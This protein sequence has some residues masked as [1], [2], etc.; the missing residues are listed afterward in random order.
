MRT[1]RD[2]IRVPDAKAD[3]YL[4]G[5]GIGG[6]DR[7]SVEADLVLRE[8]AV[9]LHL[10][11]F[12]A[13]LRET[14]AGQVVDLAA[15]YQESDDALAVY[16][17]M[18][19]HI[20][21]HLESAAFLGPIAFVCYG[22]PLYLVDSSWQLMDICS[23]R[24]YRVKALAAPTFVG[25]A[26][27]DL[28]VRFDVGFQCYE[29]RFFHQSEI[30]IDARIPLVLAEVGDFG[31]SRLRD[32]KRSATRVM[33]LLERVQSL[34]PGTRRCAVFMLSWR[35]DMAPEV[36]WGTVGDI[37]AL[38]SSVHIGSSLVITG[39]DRSEYFSTRP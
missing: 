37:S 9:V 36:H 4:V 23:R 1:L 25:Q 5:L 6:F 16:A 26:L 14:Y 2:D 7:R 38:A 19:A 22:H 20:V 30:A 12:D 39:D 33:P 29:A 8:C 17:R 13:E 3:L 27:A 24:G 10:T 15:I 28:G 35:E 32:S 18:A 34:Y 31:T 11:A 21:E